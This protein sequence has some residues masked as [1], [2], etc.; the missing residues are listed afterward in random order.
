MPWWYMQPSSSLAWFVDLLVRATQCTSDRTSEL[1]WCIKC[2]AVCA[3][4]GWSRVPPVAATLLTASVLPH[5]MCGG[6][7]IELRLL[8]SLAQVSFEVSLC[9]C[10]I[11]AL[12][13][14]S[15]LFE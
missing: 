14:D 7:E 5:E 4:C 3:C 13:V 2:L 1:E 6:F 9:P 15:V 8:R 10:Q 11:A 12:V